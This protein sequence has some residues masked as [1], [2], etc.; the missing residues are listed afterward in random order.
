MDKLKLQYHIKDNKHSLNARKRNKIELDLLNYLDVIKKEIGIPIEIKVEPKRVG[1]VIEIYDFDTIVN[2][3]NMFFPAL[4][5]VGGIFTK[6]LTNYLTKYFDGTI[7]INKLEI[8]ERKQKLKQ[9]NFL[10]FLEMYPN[11]INDEA[12][13]E[14]IVDLIFENNYNIPKLKKL[15]SKYYTSLKLTNE[16]EAISYQTLD[17]ND[18]PTSEEFIIYKRDFKNYIYSDTIIPS[19]TIFNQNIEIISP[20]LNNSSAKWR[21]RKDKV[22]ILFRMDDERFKDGVQSKKHSFKNG[23]EII[24]DMIIEKKLDNDG[25]IIDS[26]Y[27]VTK[28]KEFH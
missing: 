4:T 11:E 2:S 3:I 5:Y 6:V 1:S 10:R 16:I 14:K 25:E 12:N 24:C 26:N 17:K 7:E 19:E 23:S 27:I 28:V 21:G 8:E 20:V 22:S 18:I 9:D 15:F 13:I